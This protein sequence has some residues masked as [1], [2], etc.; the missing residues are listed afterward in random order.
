MLVGMPDPVSE[1]LRPRPLV[2]R[3][4]RAR[5]LDRNSFFDQLRRAVIRNEGIPGGLALLAVAPD[6]LTCEHSTVTWEM[7]EEICL[8]TAGRLVGYLH[9]SHPTTRVGG[10]EFLVLAE[11]IGAVDAAVYLAEQIL[12]AVR[13]PEIVR[14]GERSA[15]AS[16]GIAMPEPRTSAEQL[17]NNAAVAMYLARTGGGN[18]LQV[19]GE[20]MEEA[21][22]VASR[23]G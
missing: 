10:D 6:P 21:G 11:S 7:R 13:E 20:W 18:G 14:P 1:P 12:F 4:H 17:Q 19:Y 8:L 23:A 3:R 15:T 2:P 16:V 5:L 9:Y 22:I